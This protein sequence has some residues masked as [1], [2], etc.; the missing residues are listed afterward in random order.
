MSDFGFIVWL[1]AVFNTQET[2]E[3]LHCLEELQTTQRLESNKSS[4]GH[5]EA[6]DLA[7]L[8]DCVE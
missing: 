5:M 1:Q 2:C 6:S 3:L 8:T 4:E 7:L